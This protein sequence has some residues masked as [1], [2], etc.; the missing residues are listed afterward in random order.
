MKHVLAGIRFLFLFCFS[1]EAL[2]AS[3]PH[4]KSD[5]LLALIKKDPDGVPKLRHQ[6]ELALEYADQYS[7]NQALSWADSAV[8]TADALLK[9]AGDKKTKQEI[10]KEQTL[11]YLEYGAIYYDHGNFPEAQKKYLSAL[12]RAEKS[13]DKKTQSAAFNSLGNVYD[14]QA[15][16]IQA[17]KNYSLA[18]DLSASLSDSVAMARCNNNIGNVYA[19]QGQ[20]DKA[21]PHYFFSLGV[22]ARLGDKLG[23]AMSYNNIAGVYT[24]KKMYAEA[25]ETYLTCMKL[26]EEI[27]DRPG[28]AS[29]YGNI[30]ELLTRQKKYKEAEHYVILEEQL[31][32]ET[33]FREDLSMAYFRHMFLDSAK[34]DFKAAFQHNKLYISLRD[35][36][37]NEES[38]KKT[39]QSQVTYE[40]EKKEAVQQAEHKKEL[41]TQQQVAEEKSHK[42]RVVLV[43]VG[44]GLGLVLVF[45]GFILRSLRIT[46]KQKR[47]IETQKTLVEKQKQEVEHQKILV[48]E[49]Q[50]EMIDSITYARRLQQAILPAHK[51]I[52][53]YLKDYFIFYKPKDIVAGDFYWFHVSPVGN[54]IFLAAAD[55]TGHGVPGAMVSVVCSNA[56]NRAVNEFNLLDTGRILD[57]TREL[58]LETF[59]KSGEEIKD[60]M[61]ISLLCLKTDQSLQTVT[62]AEWSGANN[63]LWYMEGEVMHEIKPDKQAIGKT[64]NP[65]PFTTHTVDCN[66]ETHFYLLTDG[67]SDQFG[68]EKGKKF[69]YK[70]LQAKLKSIYSKSPADQESE[71]A[72]T[73]DQWKGNLEQV[74]DITIIG[75]RV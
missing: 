19:E 68:G 30:G 6:R 27:G 40:F 33:G 36:L 20:F 52:K 72:G 41:E 13:G 22:K 23:M 42:Q 49:H 44:I 64:E 12:E 58:V 21:L 63:P 34:G 7:Y 51:E 8:T 67:Y 28:L 26:R 29:T 65:A 66:T 39:F 9:I 14:A 71:L 31:C 57:K 38:R 11:A 15:D 1:S 73:L 56:L 59:A 24:E 50:K 61:D 25:L 18:L 4:P 2:P 43:M 53:Q 17:L 46:R 55:S 62:G 45:S 48:E 54:R 5:S 10:G 3:N 37:N 35:S 75:I 47:I 16:F 69:K 60:G 32:R 74:D 70:Q